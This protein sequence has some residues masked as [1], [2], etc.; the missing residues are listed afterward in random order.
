M[1]LEVFRLRNLL[2]ANFI[3][4]L[5]IA[6]AAILA[7]VLT[8]YLQDVMRFTPLLTGLAF[9]PAALGGIVGGSIAGLV[10]KRL[11]MRRGAVIGIVTLALG[12][13]L[14]SRISAEGS[15]VLVLVG[16][17]VA[18]VGLVSTGVISTICHR[19]RRTAAPGAGGWTPQHV[20]AGRWGSRNCAG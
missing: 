3:A 13:A 10:V 11:G 17:G 14:L 16:Y 6:A 18:P 15:L 5:N 9:L 20:A 2:V 8:L 12:T 19:W 7:F 4:F 1:P